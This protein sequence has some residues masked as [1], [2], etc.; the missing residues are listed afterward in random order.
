MS[1]FKVGQ[2][3]KIIE[4][5]WGMHPCHVG[6]VVTIA[7]INSSGRYTTEETLVNDFAT[8]YGRSFEAVDTGSNAEQIRAINVLIKAEDQR[9]ADAQAIIENAKAA[10][11]RLNGRR[12][13]LVASL[14]K[15]FDV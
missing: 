7:E 9:I 5:G 8:H 14:L 11:A 15:E 3:V 12:Q 1:E 6:L 13:V 2:K 4:G 10:K